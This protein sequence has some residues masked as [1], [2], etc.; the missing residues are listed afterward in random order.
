MPTT[1]P[2]DDSK[3]STAP[4]LAIAP[5][6]KDPSTGA[7]YVHEN[8]R[9]VAGPWESEKHVS[10]VE[11]FETLGD[12]ESWAKY[13]QRFAQA[14]PY[15]PLLTWNSHGL[16][17]VLDYHGSSEEP[18]RAQWIAEQPF[19]RSLEWKA[20]LQ[21]A[22][23]HAKDQ[24]VAI[25][26]I[27]DRGADIVDPPQADLTALLRSLRT[28]VN[29]NATTEIRPDGSARVEFYG[30]TNVAARGGTA[31]VPATFQIAIPVLKGHVNVSG[32]P[33]KY[34]LTVRI[35]TSPTDQAK[36]FL[37]F[38]IPDAE[39]VL[40]MVLADQVRAARELLGD[41]FTLLRAAG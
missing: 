28:T 23:G 8:L 25:E 3:L 24:R 35:R 21:L 16:R 34:G 5:V 38:S 32:Q 33:I 18:G 22:D 11:T 6:Y 26:A 31:D 41:G 20:W 29:K 10:P 13:V 12:V 36:L 19:E 7:L 1:D 14:A 27:E 15:E 30:D 39:R 40:E 9:Q 37:R 2:I 4:R 17:A